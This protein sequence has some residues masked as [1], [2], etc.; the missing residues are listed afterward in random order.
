MAARLAGKKTSG[1]GIG[2]WKMA[3][4]MT[5]MDRSNEKNE[6]ASIRYALDN[7]VN[8]IDT[9]EIYAL[10]GAE[11]LVAKAIKGY[12]REQLII[13]T[14][15]FPN[16]LS[17]K[18]VIEA[19]KAS[20]NR[21]DI[22]YIDLYLI[23]WPNPLV[24]MSEPIRA[25]ED[26]I[27]LGLVRSVGVSNFSSAQVKEAMDAAMAHKIEANQISYSLL[28]R[29]CEN[30]VIPFCEK[31][32]IQIIS[33]TPL[34]TGKAMKIAE[35]KEIAERLHKP[36]VQVALNYVKRRSIPIPKASNPA[37]MR[38]IVGALEWDLGDSD[39]KKLRSVL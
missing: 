9:A 20:L 14:K 38:E 18:Q 4:G 24:K 10:G 30:D 36:P 21:L 35:V 13:I 37:H 32:G 11:K 7:G 8:V 29:D 22:G 3:G 6:L 1:I 5:G 27:D 12:D 15:V 17:H 39:Y 2:T 33:Y 23:H 26:L 28:D 25:I 34:A 19:A 31:N 16:H